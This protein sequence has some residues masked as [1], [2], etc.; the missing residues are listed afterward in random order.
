MEIEQIFKTTNSGKF[1]YIGELV[2]C[3]DCKHRPVLD[4]EYP[5]CYNNGFD[6]KFPD[7]ICPC[8]CEDD[9]YYSWRPSDGW[10]CPKG[11]RANT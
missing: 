11:E 9:E 8:R 3:K 5:G 2:R 7:S 1:L 6:L 4:G 10:Y